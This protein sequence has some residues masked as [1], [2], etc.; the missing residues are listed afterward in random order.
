MDDR[1]YLVSKINEATDEEVR[2]L[3][4]CFILHDLKSE[5]SCDDE[6]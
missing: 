1:E 2:E 5:S 3:V 6:N 4:K